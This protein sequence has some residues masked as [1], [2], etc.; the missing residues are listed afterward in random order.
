MLP[1]RLY[2]SRVATKG[3]SAKFVPNT[4]QGSTV[5]PCDGDRTGPRA[6]GSKCTLMLLV[7]DGRRADTH[8]ALPQHGHPEATCALPR[9]VHGV[10]L[11]RT[12]MR[13]TQGMHSGGGSC[14]L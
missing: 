3:I 10:A 5:V 7:P 14:S 12:G 1:S 2:P 9:S 6:S 8:G 13:G 11:C 4:L